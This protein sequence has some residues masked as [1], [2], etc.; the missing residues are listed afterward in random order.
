MQEWLHLLQPSTEDAEDM[1]SLER[2]G[3][4]YDAPNTETTTNDSFLLRCK[5]DSFILSRHL[6][7]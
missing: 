5:Q 1:D 6:K 4:L 2:D 3:Q 7:V